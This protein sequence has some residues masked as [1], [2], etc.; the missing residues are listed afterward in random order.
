MIR[1]TLIAF[2]G[3]AALAGPALAQ[4]PRGVLKTDIVVSRDTIT[5][6]DLVEGAGTAAETPVFRAPALGRN[7]TIQ[8]SRVMD[9]ARQ[10]GI[11]PANPAGAVQVVVSRAA[12][13]IGRTEIEAAARSALAARFGMEEPDLAL[14]LDTGENVLL[15]EPEATGEVRLLDLFYDARARR[16]EATVSVNGSRAL[17]LKPVR[18][19]GQV[20]DLVSVPVAARTIARGEPIREADLRM[21]RR[22]RSELPS[23]VVTGAGGINGKVSRVQINSGAMLRE[24]DLAKQE[25]V[26]KNGVV[27]V[28]FEGPGLALTMRAKALEAGGIGDVV[29]LQNQQSKRQIQG[30]V[31]GPGRVSVTLGLPGPVASAL[32]TPSVQ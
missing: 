25:L 17:T 11:V 18:V 1:A 23:G 9:A 26:E 19:T 13:K 3:L 28:V 21:E 24:A 27:T 29:L 8:V 4:E 12:R 15:I 2:A 16:L 7:G 20:I 31:V 5:L 30:T 10:A 22:P 32:S 14:A 6:G